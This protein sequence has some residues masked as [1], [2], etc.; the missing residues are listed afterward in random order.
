MKTLHHTAVTRKLV[1]EELVERWNVAATCNAQQGAS[2]TATRMPENNDL[3]GRMRKNDRA[4]RA[5]RT[6]RR[7]SKRLQHL[8]QHPFDFVES[9]C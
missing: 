1:K 9:Q 3:I 8:L 5:Q 4:A 6:L 7:P 2:A